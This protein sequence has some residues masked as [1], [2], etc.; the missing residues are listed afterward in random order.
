MAKRDIE[1]GIRIAA[2]EILKNPRLRNKDIL[3]WSNGTLPVVD[4]TE[5]H[6]TVEAFNMTWNVAVDAAADKR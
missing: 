4:D 2:A 5:I 3:A 6:I 1:R